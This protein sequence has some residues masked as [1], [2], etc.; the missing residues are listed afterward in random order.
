VT[1]TSLTTT[2]LRLAGIEGVNPRT[3]QVK[4]SGLAILFEKAPYA[5]LDGS[6]PENLA[7]AVLDVCGAPAQAER[8]CHRGE[9]VVIAGAAGKS[10]LLV[11]FVA[12]RAGATVVA[13]VRNEEEA[14]R[15]ARI[16]V[17]AH[18]VDCTDPVATSDLVATVTGGQM[19]HV[20]FNCVNVP[21][22]EMSCI[23]AA[24]DRGKVYFFS[25]ATSFQAAALGAEAVGADVDLLIGNGFAS[26]H[27]A[28][29]LGLVRDH[30]PLREALEGMVR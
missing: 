23:L 26:G 8:L 1:L 6:L 27:A 21:G 5:K 14:A 19:G 25:M 15:L 17:A 12:Q 18:V 3:H 2:P 29:A 11:S 22:V 24:R 10:G 30:Q 20:V 16:G 7:M 28:F 4:A 13:L 9:I